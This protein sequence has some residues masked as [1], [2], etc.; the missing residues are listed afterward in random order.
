M[1]Q[2]TYTTHHGFLSFIPSFHLDKLTH[3]SSTITTIIGGNR[4]GKTATVIMDF[5]LRLFR[6]HPVPHKNFYDNMPC[7]TI[8][9]VSKIL[10]SKIEGHDTVRNTQYPELI[11][12]LPEELIVKDITTKNPVLTIKDPFYPQNIQ[13]EF[14][15]FSQSVGSMAGVERIYVW[16]DECPP[17]SVFEEN[18]MRLLSTGGDM[19]I[20]LTPAESESEWIY[21]MLYE[22]ARHIYRS[23]TV[24]ERLIEINKQSEALEEQHFPDN[25]DITVIYVATDDNPFLRTIYEK[26]LEKFKQLNE[27]PPYSSFKDFIS[28]RFYLLAEE[29]DINVRRYGLFSNISGRVFKDFNQI[30]HVINPLDYFGSTSIPHEWKHFRTIDYH[31]SNDWACLWGAISPSN[32]CFI[33]DELKISPHSHTLEQI[34]YLIARK[35]RQYRYLADLIDPRAQIK[36]INTSTSPVQELN[37]IFFKLKQEGICS[38]AYWRSFDTISDTGREEIRKRLKGSIQCGRPFNNNEGAIPT[39]WFF[40]TCRYT[41][42]SMKNWSYE[43]WKNRDKLLEK[44]LKEKPQQKYSHFCTALEGAMKE[45]ALVAHFRMPLRI[46]MPSYNYFNNKTQRVI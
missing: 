46:E 38:G 31:E 8:R 1:K 25:Q 36:S 7:K 29:S 23:K 3:S 34:A 12:R 32:E 28:N 13:V 30:V 22:R 41:I 33:Y 20:T 39:I 37:R 11:K 21:T 9:F 26:E 42:E 19:I 40:S 10:P 24:V 17:Y 35:S 14:T 5:M 2:T 27:H 44:D 6:I 18:Y 16:I 15:S 43:T 4:S 45:K